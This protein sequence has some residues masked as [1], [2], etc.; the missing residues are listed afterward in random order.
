MPTDWSR[1][2][3]CSSPVHSKMRGAKYRIALIPESWL[4]LAIRMARRIGTFRRLVKNFEAVLRSP[5]EA[6]TESARLAISASENSGLT[7][8]KTAMP[9]SRCPPCVEEGR[10]SL[11]AQHPAPGH[12]LVHVL[13][14]QVVGYV[15]DEDTEHDVELEHPGQPPPQAGRGDLG[16]VEGRGHGRGPHAQAADEAREHEGELVRRETRPDRRDEVEDADPEKRLPAADTFGRPP[17]EERSEDGAPQSG[18]RAEPVHEGV[19]RPQGLDL[20]FRARDHDG[21]EAEEEAGQARRDGPG[22]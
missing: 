22:E 9:A 14:D 20:L 6:A 11:H 7:L 13:P 18:A 2:A 5:A 8:R 17:A 1:A 4:K 3:L 21:V 15:R 12:V 10:D 19:E 16:D